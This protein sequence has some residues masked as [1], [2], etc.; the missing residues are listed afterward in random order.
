MLRAERFPSASKPRCDVQ[1]GG[2]PCGIDETTHWTTNRRE[3]Q[4]NREASGISA[5]HPW[6]FPAPSPIPVRAKACPSTLLRERITRCP[7]QKSGSGFPATGLPVLSYRAQAGLF[8][9]PKPTGINRPD[10]LIRPDSRRS[11][12]EYDPWE[13]GF[14]QSGQWCPCPRRGCKPC[15]CVWPWMRI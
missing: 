9:Q 15:R 4:K 14:R 1:R 6:I 10:C 5:L 2:K 8:Q 13:P 12:R 11:R 3:A 7:N